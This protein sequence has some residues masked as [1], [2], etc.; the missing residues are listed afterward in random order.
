[1]EGVGEVYLGL[2]IKNVITQDRWKYMR[3]W[4]V[5]LRFHGKGKESPDSRCRYLKCIDEVYVHD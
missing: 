1:M 5:V 2:L 3:G 4:D